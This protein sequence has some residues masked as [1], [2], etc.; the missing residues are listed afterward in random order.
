M[1]AMAG[2]FRF[3][4]SAQDLASSD[5][6]ERLNIRLERAAGEFCWREYRNRLS[7]A[8]T[9]RSIIVNDS[10]RQIDNQQLTAYLEN[11]APP[12]R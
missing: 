8:R 4:Y 12:A 11:N 9:C 3:S 7:A 2:D 10:V 6:M 1:P 5:R